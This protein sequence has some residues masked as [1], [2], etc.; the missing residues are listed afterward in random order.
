MENMKR[1]LD[2]VI[3]D[4]SGVVEHIKYMKTAMGTV[5]EADFGNIIRT[6]GV[7]LTSVYAIE[8]NWTELA[9]DESENVG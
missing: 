5:D 8:Q 7:V 3:A 4:L 2:G 1:D 6:L 9:Y